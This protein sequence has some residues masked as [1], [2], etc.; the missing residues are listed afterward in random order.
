MAALGDEFRAARESRGL[1]L[2]EVHERI[3][4]RPAYLEAIE[5]EDWA[6]IGEPVYVR[7]FLR[8]YARFLGLDGERAVAQFGAKSQSET[9]IVR[10]AMSASAPSEF[11]RTRKNSPLLLVL[12]IVALALVAFVGYRYYEQRGASGDVAQNVVASP[13]ADARPTPLAPATELETAA[14]TIKAKPVLK[15]QLALVIT[16]ASWVRIDIDGR[17]PIIATYPA[18]TKKTFVGKRAYVRAGNAGG[19]RV[20][21]NGKDLGKMG[22]PGDVVE[23]TF[24]L[25]P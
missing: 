23:R 3:H 2:E 17:P 7:G 15:N 5:S 6:S 20:R 9:P 11:S 13:L 4:L 22:P 8:T 21:V 16:Q 10:T 12:G 24:T 25:A 14:P 19:V 1:S 18:G